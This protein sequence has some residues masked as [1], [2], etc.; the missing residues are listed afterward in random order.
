MEPIVAPFVTE[1]CFA[2]GNFVCMVRE[3]VINTST[4]N[5]HIFTKVLKADCGAFNMPTGIAYPVKPE[6]TGRPTAPIAM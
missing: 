2:L 5:I 1:I 6:K 4:V 3:C